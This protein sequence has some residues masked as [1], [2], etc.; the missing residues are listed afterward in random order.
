[1]DQIEKYLVLPLGIVYA[2]AWGITGSFAFG[3]VLT[4]F[5]AALLATRRLTTPPVEAVLALLPPDV[6]PNIV[7]HRGAGHDAPENT[8]AAAR[9]VREPMT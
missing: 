7:A 1:M 6:P 2:S 5:L 9:L 8:L 3:L 4:M